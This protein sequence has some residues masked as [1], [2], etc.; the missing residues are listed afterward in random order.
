MKGITY[1]MLMWPAP[2]APPCA[3]CPVPCRYDDD[4]SGPLPEPYTLC[5]LLL[6]LY[7]HPET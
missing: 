5:L 6:Y 1:G 2:L 3:L 7:L 4:L